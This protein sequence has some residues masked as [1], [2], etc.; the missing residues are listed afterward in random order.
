MHPPDH[1]CPVRG[2][3]QELGELVEPDPLPHNPA[4][5]PESA[6]LAQTELHSP[7]LYP[8]GPQVC[9][10]RQE[11]TNL[12]PVP[13]RPTPEHPL[14]HFNLSELETTEETNIGE[15]PDTDKHSW[16]QQDSPQT[17]INREPGPELDNTNESLISLPKQHQ[18][19]CVEKPPLT[20][21]IPEARTSNITCKNSEKY[22]KYENY[23]NIKGSGELVVDHHHHQQPAYTRGGGRQAADNMNK[24]KNEN[25]AE[26]SEI[27]LLPTKSSDS[28]PK[29]NSTMEEQPAVEELKN[30]NEAE[31][32]ETSLFPKN[33]TN[34]KPESC[35]TLGEQPESGNLLPIS[36][37]K[38][39]KLGEDYCG[40]SRAYYETY[41]GSSAQDSDGPLVV[42]HD[43]S[44]EGDEEIEVINELEAEMDGRICDLCALD[45][46]IC[47]VTKLE[48]KIKMLK[49][50]ETREDE[51]EI[52]KNA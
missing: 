12:D 49:E 26:I 22:E 41:P 35:L 33:I 43:G 17:L 38:L 40:G 50:A 13:H 32:S 1:D 30:E 3:H 15:V 28:K 47:L 8:P 10:D 18:E 45:L 14:D 21:L 6:E 5:G 51:D 48:L 20:P 25:E 31:K 39:E 11:L 24:V 9:K 19:S 37:L 34:F 7:D 52:E 36:A 16:N 23:E 42:Q 44:G 29:N 27:S 2:D 46:C 4:H